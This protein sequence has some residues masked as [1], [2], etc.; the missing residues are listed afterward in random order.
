M[1]NIKLKNNSNLILVSNLLIT[2]IIYT[3]NKN[4][5]YIR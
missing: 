2:E 3:K 5:F 4:L 1:S